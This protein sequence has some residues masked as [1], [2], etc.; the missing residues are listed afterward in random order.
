[1]DVAPS[2][3]ILLEMRNVASSSGTR[4]VPPRAPDS[5]NVRQRM[6]SR[7]CSSHRSRR[8]APDHLSGVTE[9]T[10]PWNDRTRLADLLD[11]HDGRLGIPL[12]DDA[13]VRDVLRSA[14]RIAVVGASNDPTRPSNGVLRDLRSVGLR[15]RA[16]EPE[17]GERRRPAPAT[18]IWPAAVAATGRF[19]IVDVFRR[20]G[21][22]RPAMPVRRS[23]PGRAACG[24]SSGS[25]AARPGR[26]AAR[27]RPE[28]RRW[29]AARA[30]SSGG[31]VGRRRERLVSRSP[32]QADTGRGDPD[33]ATASVYRRR[34]RRAP[35]REPGRRLRRPGRR[36]RAARRRVRPRRSARASCSWPCR[37]PNGSPPRPSR[38]SSSARSASRRRPATCSS[39]A[40]SS[41]RARTSPRPSTARG[42]VVHPCL[43][44]ATRRSRS[45]RSAR[46]GR[47]ATAARR[48]PSSR[49]GADLEPHRPARHTLSMA[50]LYP[51][52]FEPDDLGEPGIVPGAVPWPDLA[53]RR[54]PPSIRRTSP[55]RLVAAGRRAH[56]PYSRCPAAVAL[57]LDRR[58]DRHR[59]HH[60]E[61]RVRPDD[62]AAPGRDR[63]TPGPRPRLCCDRVGHARHD[64]RR[65]GPAG[66]RDPALLAAIAPGVTARR[67]HLGL[68][69][70]RT[71]RDAT[72]RRRPHGTDP[73]ACRGRRL[74]AGRAP[75]R[76][77]EPRHPDGRP[78]RWRPRGDAPRE[79]EPRPARL[80]RHARWR[81]GLGP[82]HDD[83][84]A[85]DDDRRGGAHQPRRHD[86]H[87][88]RDVRRVRGPADR[89]RRRGAGRGLA[90]GHRPHAW[91]AAN[92]PPRPPTSRS[93]TPWPR[94]AGR[95][96]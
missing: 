14:R 57:G 86:V 10:D 73:P 78:L 76:R 41:S 83:G 42:F 68:T 61:R 44:A 5:R 52:P 33:R 64:R 45:W 79:L 8:R 55:R 48:S 43:R 13:G 60:R 92:R 15:D 85:D 81:P 63:R 25:R 29:T 94:R 47:A 19:D 87:P 28:G 31:W 35:R 50:D 6:L 66:R 3:T 17:R 54:R 26:I 67:D 1:M 59:R 53:T 27:W 16:G 71:E 84:H 40:T 37:P 58:P 23:R 89:R 75:A 56:A 22:V 46:L 39:A 91:A 95:P 49:P 72:D 34:V 88:R 62:R 11:L 96:A 77:P 21:P 9:L 69:A 12:L 18:R 7:R 38:A 30:S 20:A 24:S 74:R 2:A 36:G 4:Q 51:W 65:S 70:P 90:L 82:D 80:H 93:S 32:F